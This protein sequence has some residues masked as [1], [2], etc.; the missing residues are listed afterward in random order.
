MRR[1]ILAILLVTLSLA[2]AQTRMPARQ[3]PVDDSG[4]TT[5]QPEVPTTQSVF[6]FL[7]TADGLFSG[8]GTNTT[9]NADAWIWL[10]ENPSVTDV[11]DITPPIDSTGWA[12]LEPTNETVQ[13]T[14]DFIDT[15]G[16]FLPGTNITGATYDDGVWSI[17]SFSTIRGMVPT[18]NNSTS[19]IVTTGSALLGGEI[20]ILE[21]P[22]TLDLSGVLPSGRAPVYIYL[23]ETSTPGNLSFSGSTTAPTYPPETDGWYN[24]AG[25]RMIGSVRSTHEAATVDLFT[26]KEFAEGYRYYTI[27]DQRTFSA[28]NESLPSDNN[29]WVAPFGLNGHSLATSVPVGAQRVDVWVSLGSGTQHT[30]GVSVESYIGTDMSGAS[31]GANRSSGT[32]FFMNYGWFRTSMGRSVPLNLDP[33]A[34]TL[35]VSFMQVTNRG[36]YYRYFDITGWEIRR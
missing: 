23:D 12:W 3:V 32:Y 2:H 7:D 22:V 15:E 31:L 25:D 21:D 34:R 27:G 6:D 20:L 5:L 13:A 8:H 9:V 10:M 36:P 26:V 4:W 35:L 14:F 29:K 24:V 1:I 17:P 19:V 28:H 11:G 18:Y 33:G 30:D 16:P